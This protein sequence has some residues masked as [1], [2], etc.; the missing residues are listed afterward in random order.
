MKTLQEKKIKKLEEY[1]KYLKSICG[2]KSISSDR[3]ESELASIDKEI[4]EKVYIRS[5]EDLPE[6][7]GMYICMIQDIKQPALLR[8]DIESK[9]KY[10]YTNQWMKL[11]DWYLRPLE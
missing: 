10:G 2:I 4:F 7:N 9:G 5:E 11:V 3:Y 6:E 8:Y 1:I